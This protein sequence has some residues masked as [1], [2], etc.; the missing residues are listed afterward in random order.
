MQRAVCA[1]WDWWSEFGTVHH[2]QGLIKDKNISHT[3]NNHV[4][5]IPII[6]WPEHIHLSKICIQS[7]WIFVRLMFLLSCRKWTILLIKVGP[8]WAPKCSNCTVLR[9]PIYT[10][11]EWLNCFSFIIW[12]TKPFLGSLFSSCILPPFYSFRLLFHFFF[13]TFSF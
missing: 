4:D 6:T 10:E 2:L 13:S 11:A 12:A 8:Q 9:H 1:F 7:A 3:N 5:G